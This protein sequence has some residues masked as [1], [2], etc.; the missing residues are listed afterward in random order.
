MRI[1]GNKPFNG[2]G[3]GNARR[4]TD[5][6]G[7]AFT[8]EEETPAR[9]SAASGGAP[10][11]SGVDALVALQSVEDRGAERNRRLRHGHDMLDVLEDLKIGVLGGRI[12]HSRL[13]V[14]VER[15]RQRPER[16]GTDAVE[17]LLD[18]IELRARVELAK[19]GREAA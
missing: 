10:G 12:P 7:S 19:L 16:L 13:E 5:R 11:I 4:S 18:E 14:L 15:L 2:I 6:S 17:D 1:D 8:I 9:R 3:R